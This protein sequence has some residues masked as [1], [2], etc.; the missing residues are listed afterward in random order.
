[1]AARRAAAKPA[2]P[3]PLP[4]LRVTLE[5]AQSLVDEQLRRGQGIRDREITDRAALGDTRRDYSTW[6]EYN[7]DLLRMILST[8]E[9]A[10]DFARS[11]RLVGWGGNTDLTEDVK[12]LRIDIGAHL[13]RL[14]SVRERLPLY[15]GDTATATPR[16]TSQVANGRRV[17][18]VHGHDHATLDR[19]VRLLSDLDLEPVV[20][21]DQP[22][23]GRTI[24]EKFEAHADVTYAIV[25]MTGD[26]LGGVA[27]ARREEMRLRARQNVVL[28]LGFFIGRLTRRR[29]AA[30]VE[31]D[32][33]RPSD[34]DGVLYVPLDD[35]GI[36]RLALAKEM[37]AAGLP[38]DLNRI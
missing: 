26:D 5:E 8:G 27:N 24:I 17:F 38:V 11:V 20:L 9:V 31:R 22:N 6:V 33:E 21:R 1:M 28:E 30:L 15:G 34:I 3:A 36:W 7:R 18:V 4:E 23:E 35:S 10:E 16:T 29:V 13:R 14:E 37:K 12:D 25:L 2:D 19:V 32:V